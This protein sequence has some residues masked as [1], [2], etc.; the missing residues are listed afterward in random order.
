MSQATGRITIKLDGESL[1]SKSGASIQTGGIQRKPEM[2]DQ[3]EVYY[4]ESFVPAQVKCTMPH[5]TD[6]NLS[7]LRAFKNGTLSVVTDTGVTFT[8]A[9][10]FS[11]EVGELQNG[12]VDVTFNGQPVK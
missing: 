4:Q 7:K 1:R 10:A 6:T 9:K 2:T 5:M 12:E 3:G 11:A 8:I